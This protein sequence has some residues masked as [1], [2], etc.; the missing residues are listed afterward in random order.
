MS[1]SELLDYV[2]MFLA[3]PSAY[4]ATGSFQVLGRQQYIVRPMVMEDSCT[5]GTGS[6]NPAVAGSSGIISDAA[7]AHAPAL[8]ERN[9]R[10]HGISLQQAIEQVFVVLWNNNK[11]AE[12]LGAFELP[13]SSVT[14]SEKEKSNFS[15]QG[16][17]EGREIICS[18]LKGE[19]R[20]EEIYTNRECL[21]C[22][23]TSFTHWEK[24]I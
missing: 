18:R 1:A 12:D 17:K 13:N 22:C 10:E 24:G 5:P 7:L 19:T 21:L 9:L 2:F 16:K 20:E 11:S 4:K 15:F 8:T 14:C 6:D 3:K 23:S